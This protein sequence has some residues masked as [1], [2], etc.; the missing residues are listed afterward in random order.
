MTTTK[1]IYLYA[2]IKNAY[3]TQHLKLHV[4]KFLG[5]IQEMNTSA[6]T[7]LVEKK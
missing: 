4:Q 7:P 1:I 2:N 3:N 6:N 5:I